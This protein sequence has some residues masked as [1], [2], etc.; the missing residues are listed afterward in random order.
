MVCAEPFCY[1]NLSVA[2]TFKE[3]KRFGR[4]AAARLK[5]KAIYGAGKGKN[6]RTKNCIWNGS[7]DL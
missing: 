6:G 1:T 3:G 2:K 5:V 7:I 4:R